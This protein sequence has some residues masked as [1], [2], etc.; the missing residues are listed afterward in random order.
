MKLMLTG[1][2]CLI[3]ALLYSQNNLT[4]QGSASLLKD[5][6]PVLIQRILPRR[7]KEL[8]ADRTIT[9]DHQFSFNFKIKGGEVFSLSVGKHSATVFLQPGNAHIAL[10]DST[11]D[12]ILVTD[13]PTANEYNEYIARIGADSIIKAYVRAQQDY[14]RYRRGKLID[15]AIAQDKMQKADRLLS[16]SDIERNKICFDWIDRHPL[17]YLNTFILFSQLSTRISEDIIKKKFSSMPPTITIGTWGDEL[18][19]RIDSLSIG[20]KAPDFAQSDTNGKVVRLSDFKGRYVLVDFWASWCEPCR[21]ENPIKAKAMRQFGN[22]NFT[23]LGISLDQKKESWLQ[24]IKQDG[25]NWV[26]LSDL[27]L[28]RNAVS[29]KYYV[30]SIPG[31]YLIG[32]DGTILAKNLQGADLLAALERLI[33]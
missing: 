31:N 17:S 7:F 13:N 32:P 1:F 8:N 5:G 18:K 21:A 33:R 26:Q 14:L 12:H 6:T 25:I 15:S 16:Q 23:V 20:G 9:H 28:W 30:Y 22:R 19:Y 11:L 3:S 27:G 24:A 2:L 29:V 4:I 10:E